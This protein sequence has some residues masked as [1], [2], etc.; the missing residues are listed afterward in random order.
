MGVY[1]LFCPLQLIVLYVSNALMLMQGTA[2]E[3]GLQG[4]K[5]CTWFD[6]I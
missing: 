1:F 4:E 3:A 5:R 2:A 6:S